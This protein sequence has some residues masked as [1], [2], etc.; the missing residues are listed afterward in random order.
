MCAVAGG[1]KPEVPSL[2]NPASPEVKQAA[3]QAVEAVKVGVCVA[4]VTGHLQQG[5][6]FELTT[7]PVNTCRT[8]R[9]WQWRRQHLQPPTPSCWA[10][11]LP[12]WWG[13]VMPMLRGWHTMSRSM[14]PVLPQQSRKVQLP[15]VAAHLTGSL[16]TG[17]VAT[18]QGGTPNGT[19]N[20]GSSAPA[21]T[22]PAQSSAEDPAEEA[23][24]RAA[25]A[26]KWIEAWRS[27]YPACLYLTPPPW[28]IICCIGTACVLKLA[29]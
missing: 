29:S 11:Q 15:C 10:W 27:E 28:E 8:R 21:A 12:G 7:D 14:L 17:V 19:S 25:E 26:R 13:Q 2:P 16:H 22:A 1:V 5:T 9:H 4:A 6:E 23:K 18:Q 3:S 24:K 20:N